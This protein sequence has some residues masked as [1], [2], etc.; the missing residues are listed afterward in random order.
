MTYL[1]LHNKY[2]VNPTISQCLFCGQD[3]SEIALLG[4][5]YNEQ[6]PM[7]MVI[8][9]EPCG[10]CKE[11]MKTYIALLETLSQVKP[12]T[13]LT[14]QIVWIKDEVFQHSFNTPTPKNRI[15]FIEPGVIEKLQAM[16]CA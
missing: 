11:K 12:F 3:K 4:A 8:D 1:R 5:N 7:H 10:E 16:T 2:G 13:N 15:A 9:L 14:G 6:A